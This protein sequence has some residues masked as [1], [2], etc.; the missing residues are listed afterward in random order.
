MLTVTLPTQASLLGLKAQP[1]SF[2]FL[3]PFPLQHWLYWLTCFN[4]TTFSEISGQIA[5]LSLNQN[6]SMDSYIRSCVNG[7][8]LF[9]ISS[10]LTYHFALIRS[11]MLSLNPSFL[12]VLRQGMA[13]TRQTPLKRYLSYLSCSPFLFFSCYFLSPP[14]LISHSP[15]SHSLLRQCNSFKMMSVHGQVD[16]IERIC[17]LTSGKTKSLKL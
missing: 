13:W 10:L 14:S 11:T 2:I 16:N 12:S 3:F 1:E 8:H 4:S 9:L 7:P 6:S 17:Q 15:F 5:I